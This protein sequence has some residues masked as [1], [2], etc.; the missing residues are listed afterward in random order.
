MKN[1][2][3]SAP[4]IDYLSLTTTLCDLDSLRVWWSASGREEGMEELAGLGTLRARP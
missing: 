3:P 2:L 4:L 1:D